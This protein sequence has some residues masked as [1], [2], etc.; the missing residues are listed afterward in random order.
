MPTNETHDCLHT[1]LFTY[2]IILPEIIQFAVLF[3]FSKYLYRS[4]AVRAQHNVLNVLLF[5]GRKVHESVHY[6][7]NLIKEEYG[8][9]EMP[10]PEKYSHPKNTGHG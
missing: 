9:K 5:E 2:Y 10:L 3:P 7:I 4:H 6:L 8:F 1:L